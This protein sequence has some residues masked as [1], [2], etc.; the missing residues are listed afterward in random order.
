MLF[1]SV[2]G[3]AADGTM[4]AAYFNPRAIHVA[5]ALAS[6]SNDTVTVFIE[7]RDVNYPGSIH[8]LT[9][10]REHGYLI[11]TYFQAVQQETYNVYFRK[12]AR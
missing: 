10:D 4:D 6:L 9:Y 3:I 12:L 2:R 8:R 5:R 1:R 11:G 7:L